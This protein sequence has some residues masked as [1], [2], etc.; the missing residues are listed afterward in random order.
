MGLGYG[1]V[2]LGGVTCLSPTHSEWGCVGGR[3]EA[4]AGC[5]K[6][7]QGSAAKRSRAAAAPP[8]HAENPTLC[9]YNY[10]CKPLLY[11]YNSISIPN[12]NVTHP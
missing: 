8:G 7:G 12:T 3:Q 2:G 4:D 11:R 10:L 1:W 9:F 5:L 6:G